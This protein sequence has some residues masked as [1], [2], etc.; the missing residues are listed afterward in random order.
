MRFAPFCYRPQSSTGYTGRS[1]IL[2][3]LPM[4]EDINRLVIKR[5]NVNEIADA[6]IEQGMITMQNDGLAKAA[7]GTTT[8][9][10]VLRVAP[11]KMS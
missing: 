6:A 3:I 10:E 9:E 7:S 8:I 2:E 11:E 1:A 4:T 5:S